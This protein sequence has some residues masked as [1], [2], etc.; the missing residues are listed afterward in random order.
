MNSN[1]DAGSGLLGPPDDLVTAAGVDHVRLVYDYLNAGDLD[2]Y[3]SLLHDEV[4]F[5]LPGRPLARG[6]TEVL[7]AHRADVERTTRHE[8]D[9]VV[10][11]DH[12]VIAAGR[13]IVPG[14]DESCLRF[15]DFFGIADDSMVR[16]C[17]RYYH[18]TP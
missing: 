7:H 11:H 3:A 5:E 15:V 13:R 1:Y 17:T 18:T 2:A 8:I 4:E 16:T 9:R 10:A 6:R 12:W 14:V